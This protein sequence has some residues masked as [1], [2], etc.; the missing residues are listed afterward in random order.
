MS[1][2]RFLQAVGLETLGQGNLIRLK[3]VRVE[4]KR[5]WSTSTTL[6]LNGKKGLTFLLQRLI[7]RLLQAADD[8][9]ITIFAFGGATKPLK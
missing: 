6:G 1:Y 8:G 7:G 3:L 9:T 5:I 2:A 4:Q